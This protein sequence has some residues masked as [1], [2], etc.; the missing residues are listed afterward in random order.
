MRKQAKFVA[1]LSA[2]ALLAVGAS[3]TA[4]AATPHW[5]MEDGEWVY[6]DRNGEVRSITVTELG[7]TS[8]SGEKL[9]AAAFAYC[10]YIIEANP[11][12]DAFIMNR[13]TDAMEEVKQGLAFGIYDLDQS[14]KYILIPLNT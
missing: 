12:V 11:Y 10:Y 3:M 5:D 13:Q 9:Q 8:A 2:A 6:L 4:F 1:V 7:F 14:P